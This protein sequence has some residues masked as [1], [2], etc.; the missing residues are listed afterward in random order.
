MFKKNQVITASVGEQLP[1]NDH[2]EYQIVHNGTGYDSSDG[3][4]YEHDDTGGP[5]NYSG[6]YD[7]MMSPVSEHE[8][9]TE[10]YDY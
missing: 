10:G 4:N 6:C 3:A 2:Q 8:G 5:M 9:W 7:M 1:N